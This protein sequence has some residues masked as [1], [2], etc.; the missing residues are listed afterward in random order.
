[1]HRQIRGSRTNP[2][3]QSGPIWLQGPDRQLI[4]EFAP[5]DPIPAGRRIQRYAANRGRS[6][7]ASPRSIATVSAPP[8]TPAS[9][10]PLPRSMPVRYRKSMPNAIY[11][12]G[13]MADS[14]DKTQQVPSR[15]PGGGM[16]RREFIALLDVRLRCPTRRAHRKPPSVS[17]F[18]KSVHMHPEVHP[19]LKGILE[20]IL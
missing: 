6:F 7:R 5:A 11:D 20:P 13:I 12:T 16:R 3:C 8:N 19:G 17:G 2:P 9:L 10:G 14:A 4:Y 1:M 15:G 18:C